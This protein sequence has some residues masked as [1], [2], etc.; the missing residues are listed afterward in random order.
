MDTIGWNYFDDSQIWASDSGN[1]RDPW[2]LSGYLWSDSAG[3]SSLSGV[4][5]IPD[6]TSFS[7]YAWNDGIGWINMAGATFQ[8][9]SDGLIGKVKVIGSLGGSKSF[10]TT[11]ALGARF[12]EASM[13]SLV[14][15]VRK[16]IALLT[17]NLRPSQINTNFATTAVNTIG[18]KII[19]INTGSTINRINYNGDVKNA[20]ET[21]LGTK[22]RSL[23]VIGGNVYLDDSVNPTP[24]QDKSRVIIALKNDK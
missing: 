3:W 23:I 13:A 2:T 20:Y 11:Y 8:T 21:T 17:R 14:N 10:D 19:Y 7:G 24:G 18:D 6:N 4:T 5:Y 15:L 9:I 12:S 1:P 16:N 22:I